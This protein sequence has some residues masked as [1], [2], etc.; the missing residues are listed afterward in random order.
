M[1]NLKKYCFGT[2]VQMVASL[3]KML[4]VL[5]PSP[6]GHG[7]MFFFDEILNYLN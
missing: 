5:I 4:W 3:I 7:L 2:E 1:A 6:S